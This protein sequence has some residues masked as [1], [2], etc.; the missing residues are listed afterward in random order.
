MR[1]IR[2]VLAAVQ[3]LSLVAGF[4]GFMEQGGLFTETA[5]IME[6]K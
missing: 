1:I 4:G 3:T 5:G 2:S 6:G